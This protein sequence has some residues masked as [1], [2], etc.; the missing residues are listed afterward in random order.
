MLD[1]AAKLQKC[2]L[3]AGASHV[4]AS[5]A[6]A[7]RGAAAWGQCL[8]LAW[9][10]HHCR[11]KAQEAPAMQSSQALFKRQ[12][13][14]AGLSHCSPCSA[15]LLCFSKAASARPQSGV[16][17]SKERALALQQ[18]ASSFMPA[19]LAA[20]FRCW[21]SSCLQCWVGQ[22]FL[23]FLEQFGACLLA[24][25]AFCCWLARCCSC[26]QAKRSR[27]PSAGPPASEPSTWLLAH[28]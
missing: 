16:G 19:M 23:P 22:P 20:P 28:L 26:L 27:V 24:P 12:G 9:H 11:S 3:R 5:L 2:C 17:A 13:M 8:Q 14:A 10:L 6:R 21:G 1:A 7:R 4:L 18:G 25:M 15:S